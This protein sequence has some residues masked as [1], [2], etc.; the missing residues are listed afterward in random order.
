M[1]LCADWSPAGVKKIIDR[2]ADDGASGTEDWIRET[3]VARASKLGLSAYR[4]AAMTAG[5]V[6][7][8]HMAAYFEGRKSMSSVKLQWALKALELRIVPI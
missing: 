2:V 3:V 7:D 1:P 4:V 6:S 8:D 5:R